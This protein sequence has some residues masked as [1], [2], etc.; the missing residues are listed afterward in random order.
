VPKNGKVEK[1][2]VERKSNALASPHGPRSLTDNY[3]LIMP[4]AASRHRFCGTVSRHR[5]GNTSG[6]YDE[7]SI[8][9]KRL[10]PDAMQTW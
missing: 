2:H 10:F 5:P 4:E 6:S 7:I 8:F 9:G 1:I 3:V